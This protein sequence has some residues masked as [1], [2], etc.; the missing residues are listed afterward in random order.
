M[1]YFFPA[2]DDEVEEME[3]LQKGDHLPKEIEMG[4]FRKF[5][6]LQVGN[7]LLGIV[8]CKY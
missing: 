2:E 1:D 8:G 5:W 6:E 4:F 3:D 7:I